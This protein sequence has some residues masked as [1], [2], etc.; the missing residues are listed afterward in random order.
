MIHNWISAYQ[1]SKHTTTAAAARVKYTLRTERKQKKKYNLPS[2][3]TAVYA[4][5]DNLDES[6]FPRVGGIYITFHEH[7]I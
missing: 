4:A 7:Q 3:T 6:A 5:H 1:V 2:E